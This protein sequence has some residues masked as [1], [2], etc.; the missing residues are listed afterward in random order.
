MPTTAL[1]ACLS[2]V[3]HNVPEELLEAAF[4]PDA[5]NVS[6]DERIITEVIRGRVL[7]SANLLTGRHTRIALLNDYIENTVHTGS[8]HARTGIGD[9]TFYEDMTVF[10]IPPEARENKNISHVYAAYPYISSNSTSAGGYGTSTRDHGNSLTHMSSFALRSHTVET[11]NTR[12]VPYLLGDNLVRVY[13]RANYSYGLTLECLLEYD[14]EFTNM[15]TG[16]ISNLT[17][18]VL[19]A[20]RTFIYNK[21]IIKV[22][23]NEIIAGHSIGKFK[24]IIEEYKDSEER[25]EE[26]LMQFKASNDI[27][28]EAMERLVRFMI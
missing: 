2:H 17:Q 28:P 21:L 15:D 7:I 8:S 27:R 26:L 11:Q 22:D 4:E 24:D 20:T 10:R 12:Y 16:T 13:P 9:G 14:D 5:Y 18:L 6:L 19:N 1:T 3:Y 25:W 23:A